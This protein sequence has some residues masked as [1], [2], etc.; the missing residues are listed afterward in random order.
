MKREFDQTFKL[1]SIQSPHSRTH[2]NVAKVMIDQQRSLK[3]M[4]TIRMMN[5]IVR[6]KIVTQILVQV[7]QAAVLNRP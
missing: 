6:R 2:L 4:A 7:S 5:Q 1:I 3:K